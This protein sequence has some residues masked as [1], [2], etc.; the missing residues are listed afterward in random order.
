MKTMKAIDKFFF[1]RRIA[2]GILSLFAF[3]AFF[4]AFGRS[5]LP[6]FAEEE[7]SYYVVLDGAS[8]SGKTATIDGKTAYAL[9][10]EEEL[11]VSEKYFIDEIET[12]TA[13]TVYSVKGEVYRRAA[14]G[15]VKETDVGYYTFCYDPD[16]IS[17]SRAFADYVEE[18]FGGWYPLWQFG[19][20][21]YDANGNVRRDAEA[22]DPLGSDS[23]YYSR[24]Y[25]QYFCNF[26]VNDWELN[27]YGDIRI[28][29][30]DGSHFYRDGEN[31]LTVSETGNYI[32]LFSE[33]RVYEN[34]A[35][36]VVYSTD[37]KGVNDE[38]AEYFLCLKSENY[39]I[40]SGNLLEYIGNGEYQLENVS[41]S[42]SEEFCVSDRNGARWYSSYGDEMRVDESAAYTVKFSPYIVYTEDGEWA[43][44]DSHITYRRYEP[45]EISLSV[46]D[47]AFPMT[48]R[49]E[50]LLYDEYSLSSVY[51]YAGD[52]VCVEGR[53]ETKT[54]AANGYYR[55]LYTPGETKNGDDYLYDEEGSYGTGEGYSYHLYIEKAPVYYLVFEDEPSRSADATIEG[56]AAY[57]LTR[58]ESYTQAKA[59]E[60]FEFFVGER[61]YDLRYR[62]YEY[63][64]YAGAYR[65]IDADNDEDTRIN[66]LDIDDV[67]WYTLRLFVGE[68][69]YTSSVAEAGRNLHGW[70]LLTQGNGYGFDEDGGVYPRD[71]FLFR[72]VDEE[73]DDYTEDYE[74]YVLFVTLSEND[75]KKGDFEFFISDGYTKYK[76]LGQYISLSE[77][78][79][80]KILFSE[81]HVYGRG[82]NYRYFLQDDGAATEEVEI[83]TVAQFL[84]FAEACNRDA[85]YS[86][87]KSFY[88]TADLD[89][90]GVTFQTV[91]LFC[92]GFY[93]GY[94]AL[95]NITLSD[96]DVCVFGVVDKHARIERLSVYD[97]SIDEKDG[98]YVGFVGKNY[99]A[100]YAVSLSGKIVGGSYV[101]GIVGYNGKGLTEE[102][103]AIADSADVYTYGTLEKCV[104]EGSVRGKLN[105]GGIAGFS[106]GKTISCVSRGDVNVTSFS[107]SDNVVNTGGV[108]GYNTGRITDC[109]NEGRVGY[110]NTG[111]YVGG[112]C[113]FSS[114]EIYY[115]ENRGEVRGSAY[116]GGIVGYFGVLQE[117]SASTGLD[118]YF[119]GM[120]YEEFIS[121]YFSDAGSDFS[122]EKDSGVAVVVYCVNEG[123]VSCETYAGGVVGFA[124]ADGLSIRGCIG[125]GD[126]KATAGSYA[127]GVCAYQGGGA[128]ANC[129]S[130]G[131]VEADGLSAG[132]Y[133]GGIVGYGVDI[134][135]SVSSC[136]L[137]GADYVGGI[138]G[139]L[140]GSLVG[141]YSNVV[142]IGDAL[143]IGGVA[144]ATSSYD[145]SLNSF[146]GKVRDNFFVGD[147]GGIANVNY[148]ASYDNAA[149]NLT[150]DRLASQGTL[151]AYLSVG[152]S[153]D[154]W[155]G[156]D[157]LLSYPVPACFDASIDCAEYGDDEE[158]ASRFAAHREEYLSFANLYCAK[159]YTVI[160]LEWNEDEGDLYDEDGNL[161]KENFEVVASRRFYYGEEIAQ[162]PAFLY[163]Q[164]R[165]GAY[166]YDGDKAS[167]I[168]AWEQPEKIDGENIK[169]YAFYKEVC[170]SLAVSFD[171]DSP[172][173]AAEEV[174]IEG[175]FEEGTTAVAERYGEYYH[176]AFFLDGEEID[177]GE[178]TLKIYVGED[179]DRYAVYTADGAS[180]KKAESAVSGSYLSFT[181]NGEFFYVDKNSSA[182]P[183]GVWAAIGAGGGLLLA[184]AGVGIFVLARRKGRR[185]NAP[186]DSGNGGDGADGGGKEES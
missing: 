5:C 115:S 10:E 137:N 131:S 59:Y 103:D 55:V 168:V 178:T 104:F 148:G 184:A 132:N 67:G 139:Y 11:Y 170:T 53:S 13:Y 42:P 135:Y 8:L 140:D 35:H 4:F 91:N 114:G 164:E 80:Y 185:A 113:G 88:L 81:E 159:T 77:A 96:G 180:V 86:V 61:D 129:L 95:K 173:G 117:S 51:L 124:F 65:L 97:L 182:L 3:A 30:G 144:G 40:R 94:H 79:T 158:F 121:S 166:V 64:F 2:V 20:Y 109:V 106:S 151:S 128:I 69:T 163:A 126:V 125:V 72:L 90:R 174:F 32:L 50:N 26:W 169:V 31:Y 19:T 146:G 156:G 102:G 73:D 108:V 157:A 43:N 66:K 122:E 149:K 76:N 183:V 98:E 6:V 130:A 171:S 62:V 28:A 162:P 92:G 41:L 45:E 111:V 127:G 37:E 25:K 118:A 154:D 52:S 24:V 17:G 1:F 57:L 107:S 36:V 172:N 75:L 101:G 39:A 110:D 82:R 99:G 33:T 120:D 27:Y 119:G 186:D 165:N 116:A 49:S 85:D 152:F 153:S 175:Y 47:E 12:Q 141:C 58:D 46:G 112:V 134:S 9:S 68:E 56:N 93:G 29:V 83:N 87:N 136:V 16:M 18:D 44:T 147:F 179:A 143:H 123:N 89:F 167:Y 161:L 7:T 70:Y 22:L 181:Y 54:V 177:V 145:P 100:L 60:S 34:G 138:A 84:A 160:Y 14:I 21:M 38:D 23:P 78:G 133:V 155:I 15:S 150:P 74:Q 176:I 48:Y 142:V 105:A 63:D 71:E